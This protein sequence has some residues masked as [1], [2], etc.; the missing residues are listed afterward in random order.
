MQSSV[1]ERIKNLTSVLKKTQTEIASELGVS[2]Q[3]F[4]IWSK[5]GVDVPSSTLQRIIQTFNLS[6]NY[7]AGSETNELTEQMKDLLL[8]VVNKVMELENEIK[9]L[10]NDVKILKAEL[11]DQSGK[12]NANHAS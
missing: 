2:R 7:F 9:S 6:E 1:N 12:K 5:E 8:K 10:T 4:Y 11:N 3:T